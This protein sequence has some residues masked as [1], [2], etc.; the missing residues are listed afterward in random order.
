[1]SQIDFPKIY[2]PANQ[3]AEELI[4]NFVVRTEI[5]QDIFN[6]IK[7][8]EM[9]FPEQHYII[10]GV[11]GQG[12]TTLLLRIAY[13][14][15][16]DKDLSKSI[17]PVVFNEEQYNISRLFKLWET[18]AEY[19]EET[20]TFNGLVHEIEQIE[21]DD[22]YE[23][24]CFS[25]LEEKMRQNKKKLIVFIDNI[26]EM[27]DKFTKQEHH[28]LRE[29]FIESSELRIIGAS[30]VGLEF[31]YDYGKPFYQFFKMPQ[32]KGLNTEEIN[33]LLL[34]L[35]EHYKR[36]RIKD[37]VI[38]QPGRVEALRRITGG[39]IRTIIILFEIFVDDTNGQA[40]K[41]LEKILDIVTPL[42]K[43]RMDK[44][45]PQ[46][47]EIVDYIALKW[48]A[49]STK[50][51][52]EKV[53][54]P[55]KTVSSQLK[56]LEKFYIIEKVQ[57]STKNFMY[58]IT[59]RFFNI[60]YLMRLGRKWDERRVRFFVEFLQNWCDEKEL[61]IKAHKHLKAIQSGE[62][63][64][65]H[66]LFMTEALIRTP[67]SKE[68]QH[69]LISETRDYFK[70]HNSDL[71]NYL[72][73]SDLEITNDVRKAIDSNDLDTAIKNL[74]KIKVKD[75]EDFNALGVLYIKRDK[76]RAKE[77]LL[78]AIDKDYTGAMYNLALLYQTEFKD[79]K[80][81]EKYYLMAID[82]DHA[83]AMLNLALLYQTEF[84][85]L[86]K[87]EKYYLMAIDKDD[88]DA[89]YNLALL[90]KTEFKDLKKAEKYYL[91]AIDKDHAG[92]MFS[93][94]FLYQTGF[95]DLKKAEK[96]YLMAIDKD[97]ADAMY[98]LALLYKTEFKD[99][100]KAEKYYLMAI[101][102][103]NAGAMN[104]L[105]LLYKT[106]FKDFKKAE[107]YYL[108][109]IEKDN[110]GAMNNLAWLYFQK[111]INKEMAMK[112]ASSAYK[113][114]NNIYNTHTYATV[115]LWNDQIELSHTIAKE[116]LEDLNVI[117]KMN[118]GIVFYILF[119][120]SRKQYRLTLKIF[121]ENPF[122]FK[123]RYKPVYY[124]LMFFMQDEYPNEY[125][126]MGEELNETVQEVIDKIKKLEIDYK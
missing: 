11:R 72:T 63:N 90:Y 36:D 98:N 61:E 15:E 52:A 124:A 102:K 126:K 78:K 7:N 70:K 19:L 37:I 49:V 108:M 59:E 41:D 43:H 28:R 44:L 38:K 122:E 21:F 42:Y 47:Q 96:Y 75:S 84:K 81:A 119:L 120:I 116:F 109:A 27:L 46:Q 10:Q 4:S 76:E 105:A 77:H 24:K 13:E 2:N 32:L 57:T 91:M 48:D 74:E 58:R 101:D 55:S 103:D 118:D 83:G 66:A 1:M 60:W 97:D 51:I 8:A 18:I 30:S 9:K 117:E 16:R 45:A 65:S 100:K 35:G 22:D 34:K 89:M 112:Y 25:L 87:A 106:E 56:R 82:K 6:D 20:K 53:K 92:A 31:H 125:R 88:A 104:N 69:Q 39:V 107:K 79:L 123:D 99:F 3:T 121:D 17:I 80:K 86:K 115:L 54:L 111:K 85:D 95:K 64:E 67:L 23:S 110:A 29:I 14:I 68:T 5:F 50:E 94:A 113:I 40:F 93:L 62:I 71:M 12:K 73:R 114:E 33:T 26:D